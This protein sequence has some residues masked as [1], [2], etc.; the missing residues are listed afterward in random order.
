MSNRNNFKSLFIEIKKNNSLYIMLIPALIGFILFQY[1]PIFYS[2]IIGFKNYSI[3]DGLFKSS[4][5]GLKYFIQ[6]IND[7]FAFRLLKN[8]LLLGLYT[9]LWTFPIP[10]MLALLLNEVRRNYYK[11]FIQSIVFLPY[12][13]M[14]VVIIGIMYNLLDSDGVINTILQSIG[15][16]RINMISNPAF[17]RTI[18]II[19]EIWQKG[20]WASV[21]YL[22]A[23]SAISQELYEVAAIDGANR[24]HQ[25][26]Y[27]SVSEIRTVIVFIAIWT[28]GNLINVSFEKV[29]LMYSPATYTVSDVMQTYVYRRGIL[30]MEYGYGGAV[31][32]IFTIISISLLFFANKVLRKTTGESLW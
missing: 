14:L 22:A 16:E 26:W 4:W 17:F 6:F 18:Y 20:G 21:I 27:V 13:I 7:P 28:F 24:W 5:V 23:L 12:F 31:G 19:S 2:L 8:T 10:I 29:L 25:M 30:G 3:A 9:F 11:R 32:L 1:I 15:L